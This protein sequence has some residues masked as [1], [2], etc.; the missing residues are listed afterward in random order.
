M[1]EISVEEAE[2]PEGDFVAI[3]LLYIRSS[4]S[5]I[6]DIL[7]RYRK[8][9]KKDCSLKVTIYKNVLYSEQNSKLFRVENKICDQYSIPL[10]VGM[11]QRIEDSIKIGFAEWECRF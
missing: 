7:E 9:N 1:R 3:S 10:G 2:E 4:N 6:S 11:F 8:D 5:I